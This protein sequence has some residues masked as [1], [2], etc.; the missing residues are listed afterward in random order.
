MRFLGRQN[1][2]KYVFGRGSAPDPAGG[3]HSAPQ[4][5]WLHLGSLLV[6]KE[7]I[8]EKKGRERKKEGTGSDGKRGGAKREGKKQ[9]RGP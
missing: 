8:G 9:E 4:T 7:S 2:A 5:F 1:A 3:A 6:R